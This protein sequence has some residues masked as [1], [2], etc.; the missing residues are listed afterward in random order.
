MAEAIPF[1]VAGS[2]IGSSIYEMQQA[3]EMA[4]EQTEALN[5]QAEALEIKRKQGETVAAKQQIERSDALMQVEGEQQAQAAAQGMAESSGTLGALTMGSYNKYAESSKTGEFNLEMQE[6]GIDVQQ[7]GIEQ[8]KANVESQK[9][10]QIFGILID[11]ATKAAEMAAGVPPTGIGAGAGPTQA[12]TDYGNTNPLYSPT[13]QKGQSK[14]DFLENF[15]NKGSFAK[16][17][18]DRMIRGEQW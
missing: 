17:L 5:L 18:N 9:D 14:I 16:H 3:E 7:V 11:T 1:V 12:Q 10:A 2:F 13:P 15:R 6:L 4:A 8:K